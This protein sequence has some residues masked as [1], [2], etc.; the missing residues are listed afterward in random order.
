MNAI[1]KFSLN[2]W[3]DGYVENGDFYPADEREER[4][5]DGTSVQLL[6]KRCPESQ[7]VLDAKWTL[8]DEC[9]RGVAME[10]DFIQ[11]CHRMVMTVLQ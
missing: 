8:S 10:P 5:V 2:Y 9:D 11:A 1:D 6:I 3:F 7:S 4:D